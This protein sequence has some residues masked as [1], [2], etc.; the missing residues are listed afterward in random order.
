MHARGRCDA[1]GNK[2]SFGSV[3]WIDELFAAQGSLESSATLVRSWRPCTTAYFIDGCHCALHGPNV[4]SE[5]V[6]ALLIFAQQCA[7]DRLGCSGRNTNAICGR[8]FVRSAQQN[9]TG[10][11]S[12]AIDGHGANS[13]DS[14][15][16]AI[17]IFLQLCLTMSATVSRLLSNCVALDCSRSI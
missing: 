5:A 15:S 8:A 16:N 2:A 4:S 13:F 12:A 3:R 10:Y 7:S 11:I 9:A 6:C 1:R 14:V 17:Y